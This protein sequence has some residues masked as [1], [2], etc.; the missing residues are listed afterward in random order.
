MAEL[1]VKKILFISYQFP[2]Q[3]G[4][5]VHRSI[6]LVKHLPKFG[7]DPIV[8]TTQT[9]HFAAHGY[10]MDQKLLDQIDSQTEIIRLKSYSPAKFIKFCMK[11]KLYRFIWYFF[12]RWFWEY[13]V[14]WSTKNFKA[15]EKIVNEQKIEL[16]YTTSGPFST[17]LLGRKLKRKLGVK[18]VADLRDPFTDGYQWSFPS[19]MHWRKMRRFEKKLFSEP[20]ILVVNTDEVKK[21]YLKRNYRN[22]NSIVVINNGF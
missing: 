12:Y 2:P 1:V 3:A 22:E 18:W 6:K 21:L 16:V 5:G 7:Y 9:D 15:I 4:P 10:R 20:D 8:I 17:M 14:F 11:I 13:S 19:K